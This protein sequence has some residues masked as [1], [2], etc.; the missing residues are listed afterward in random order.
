MPDANDDRLSGAKG[1]RILFTNNT[2]G[3]RAGSELALRDLAICLMKR[4]HCPVAYSSVLGEVAAELSLATIPVIDDLGK[5]AAPPDIIHGQHHLEAVTA[6][7]HFPL[8]PALFVCHG[9]RPWEEDPPILPS[10]QHYVAVDSLCRERVV[11]TRGIRPDHVT[12][13]PNAVD[14]RHFPQRDVWRSRPQSALIFSNYAHPDDIRTHTIRAA[15]ARAG[16]ARVD[17]LGL[18][19]GNAQPDPGALL[20]D[21]D[22]VFAKARCALEA[23]ASGAAVIVTDYAGLA[24]MVTSDRVAE[25]RAWNFGARTM[26]AAEVT[27]DNLLRELQRYDADD[28][29]RVSDFIRPEA[30]LERAADR[31]LEVYRAVLAR[32]ARYGTTDA[33]AF[34]HRQTVSASKY[35]S[36]LSPLIKGLHAAEHRANL[37]DIAKAE[38]AA[39]QAA[40]SQRLAEVEGRMAQ[41]A[42]DSEASAQAADGGIANAEARISRAEART[43]EAHQLAADAEMRAQEAEHRLIEASDVA[44][45]ATGRTTD[46]EA[47]LATLRAEL[48][49][50]KVTLAAIK[51]SRTWRLMTRYGG[52]KA[53]IFS[54]RPRL[55]PPFPIIVGVPRSGTTL[56]RLMLDAH[57]Q[58]ALPPE[59]GFLASP[60][61][62]AAKAD[63]LRAARLL[64]SFPPEAPAWGDF[65]I[66]AAD[67]VHA[68]EALPGDAG[69]AEVLRLFYAQYAR[70]QRKPRSGDK[71]PLYLG[72]MTTVAS[73][74]PEA[75]FI[76]IVRDGRDVA[77][78]WRETWFAPTTSLPDLVARWASDVAAARAMAPAVNYLEIG[79]EDLVREPERQLRTICAFIDLDF[80]PDMLRYHVR[81]ADRLREHGE[82][83]MIDGNLV[84]SREQRLAQQQRTMQPLQPDRIGVWRSEMSPEDRALCHAA[85][86]GLLAAE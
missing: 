61:I 50:H 26:Q 55:P 63:R 79:Y 21:Y 18:G 34:L 65:G 53:R 16:I 7:L 69:L 36:G 49:D 84:V 38:L 20:H 9:W 42:T 68:A 11:A 82:R 47:G 10:I 31:W 1:L 41:P 28:A 77:L 40:L 30:D 59:T 62:L 19:A 52:L 70:Q 32:H 66:D 80:S 22:I 64:T 33:T 25:M 4:G 45:G 12:V 27:E 37:A 67:F 76:H 72:L 24:G 13:I 5:L 44:R 35:I 51:G 85:A 46:L 71:T 43:L 57:P 23:M 74:L 8:T 48:D 3:A 56:L 58:L 6:A 83:R 75:R 81:A 2:L 39:S 86:A 17:V 14:L 60:D 29:R 15:C 78:S 54:R 73:V